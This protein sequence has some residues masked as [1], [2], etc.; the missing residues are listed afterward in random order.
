[1]EN[2]RETLAE[3][4]ALKPEHVTLGSIRT[5]KGLQPRAPELAKFSEQSRIKD[6]SAKRIAGM[7]AE[8]RGNAMLELEPILAGRVGKRMLVVDGHHRLLA[9]RRAGRPT[10]PARVRDADMQLAAQ[11]AGLA[12][13]DF[14]KPALAKGQDAEAAW[15]HVTHVMKGRK[16]LPKGASLRKI[17]E[18]FGVA[19]GTVDSMVKRARQ[20]DPNDYSEAAKD[21]ATGWPRWKYV[22]GNACAHHYDDLPADER[23]EREAAKLARSLAL[24]LGK[25]PPEVKQRA[26][27]ML[28]VEAEMEAEAD[29]LAALPAGV[30]EEE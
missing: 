4:R 15:Q 5:D 7:A 29:A 9:Y 28:R 10:I 22:R 11:I 21:P 27:S 8:L 12:N 26:F 3:W 13:T 30:D 20:V 16:T 19:H 2:L 25:Y 17:G 6:G 24:H 18:R 14:I 23:T 1:M